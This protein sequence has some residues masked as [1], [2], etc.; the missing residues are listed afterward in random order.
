MFSGEA[1]TS[2]AREIEDKDYSLSFSY[3]NKVSQ[4]VRL[5]IQGAGANALSSVG[6]ELY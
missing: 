6:K 2:Y 5:G 1:Q 3:F 4:T